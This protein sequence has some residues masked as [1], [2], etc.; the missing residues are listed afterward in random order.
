MFMESNKNKKN[1]SS[2]NVEKDKY[3]TLLAN[4]PPVNNLSLGIPTLINKPKPDD[5]VLKY[6]PDAGFTASEE[7][8]ARLN[9]PKVTNIVDITAT[10]EYTLEEK[11]SLVKSFYVHEEGLFL[12]IIIGITSKEDVLKIM[13]EYSSIRFDINLVG[14]A[15][16]Y[17]DISVNFYFESD[18]VSELEFGNSFKGI[19]S[20]GLRIGD[21]LEKAIEIYGP[22]RMKTSIGAIWDNMKVFSDNFS[23]TGIKIRK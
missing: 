9:L 4:K 12:G 19:T 2:G 17:D 13:E 3:F 7:M 11:K 5:M 22:P 6:D 1:D 8:L 21:S 18:I 15:L 10:N 16:F 14:S 20:K 23:I